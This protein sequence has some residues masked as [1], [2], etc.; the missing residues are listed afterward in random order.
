MTG[1]VLGGAKVSD[2]P[3]YRQTK[4]ELVLNQKAA[5]SL[6]LELSAS[7]LATADAVVD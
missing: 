2:I 1:Q 5:T 3:F 4:H 7:L 6:G